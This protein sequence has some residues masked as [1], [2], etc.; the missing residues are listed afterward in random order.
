VCTST[1]VVFSDLLYPS[2]S[3]SSAIKTPENTGGDPDDH[4]PADE[5]DIQMKYCCAYLCSPSSVAVTKH[6]L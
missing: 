4:G 6:C 1:T 3:S 5:G 2:S